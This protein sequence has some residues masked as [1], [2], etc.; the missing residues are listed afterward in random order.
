MK[1]VK[2]IYFKDSGKYYTDETVEI[3]ESISG[4]EALVDE[5][6]KRQRANGMQML[7]QN[8]DN[9][10]PFIVPHLYPALG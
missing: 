7:V 1:K 2:I 6:P 9:K 8:A 4:Y 3:P 10:E 5:L